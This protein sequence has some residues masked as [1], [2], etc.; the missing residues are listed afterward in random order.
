MDFID[1]QLTPPP[2][3][4]LQG[5]GNALEC[6]FVLGSTN[7]KLFYML[8][9]SDPRLPQGAIRSNAFTYAGPFAFTTNAH[10]VARAHNPKQRQAGGP[11]SSTPWAGPLTLN[12]TLLLTPH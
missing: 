9:G 8:D 7:A 4:L 11:P 1:Q 12:T 6:R 3:L 10:L 2:R 5:T